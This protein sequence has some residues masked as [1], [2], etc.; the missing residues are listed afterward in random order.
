[1]G[2][3]GAGKRRYLAPF[4]AVLAILLLAL[5]SSLLPHLAAPKEAR[6]ASL[7]RT[8]SPPP[9]WRNFTSV[10]AATRPFEDGVFPIKLTHLNELRL[11]APWSDVWI[12]S[13]FVDSR[14]VLV[15][16]APEI[17]ILG[18]GHGALADQMA[19]DKSPLVCY[20]LVKQR[21][22]RKE[23]AVTLILPAYITALPDSHVDEKWYSGLMI[24]CPLVGTDGQTV[25]WEDADI[26][27][28]V[29]TATHPPP[30][31][32]FKRVKPLP[33][34]DAAQHRL[35]TGPGA[36]C[37]QPLVGDTYA[38]SMRDFMVYYRALG[39]TDFYAYLLDPG[40]ET[41]AI[42]RELVHEEGFHAVRW[43]LPLE[44]LASHKDYR[45]DPHEWEISG[46]PTLSRED[47]Y[48]YSYSGSNP[49]KA[50]VGVWAFA[51]NLAHHDCKF[52]AQEAGNRWTAM[53]DWDEYLLLR[54]PSGVWPP[55]T[56]GHEGS[57]IGDWAAT[58]DD[59][60]A[61]T[62]L[63]GA[64]LF[65]SAFLCILCQPST[66][67][68]SFSENFPTIDL[69][70]PTPAVPSIFV[71]P[72]RHEIWFNVGYRAK[73]LIDPW[74]WYCST[75]HQP[76]MSYAQY[77]NLRSAAWNTSKTGAETWSTYAAVL[78]PSISLVPP[79]PITNISLVMNET[80]HARGGMYHLRADGRVA[81][82]LA[83]WEST[84]NENNLD[85]FTDPTGADMFAEKRAVKEQWLTQMP[86]ESTVGNIVIVGNMV[87]DWTLFIAMSSALTKAI[88][89]RR[90]K[91]L[92]RW[93]GKEWVGSPS[94]NVEKSD[95][96]RR[97]A[98]VIIVIVVMI[99]LAS[100][101]VVQPRQYRNS[102]QCVKSSQAADLKHSN[103]GW[104]ARYGG[105]TLD[106]ALD[107][108]FAPPRDSFLQRRHHLSLQP[109]KLDDT[110]AHIIMIGSS[111]LPD[112]RHTTN[113]RVSCHGQLPG[114]TTSVHL[115]GVSSSTPASSSST[116]P[117]NIAA[118]IDEAHEPWYKRLV[119]HKHHGDSEEV[120]NDFEVSGSPHVREGSMK[121]DLAAPVET[122]EVLLNE[123][124]LSD[125]GTLVLD[126]TGEDDKII[127]DIC[128]DEGSITPSFHDQICAQHDPHPQITDERFHS[129]FPSIPAEDE[130]VEGWETSI[131]VPWTEITAVQ[132]HTTALVVNAIEIT[133]IDSTH[134]FTSFVHFNA[135]YELFVSLWEHANPEASQQHA[136]IISCPADGESKSELSFIGDDGEKKRHRLKLP[137]FPHGLRSF[138]GRSTT[139]AGLTPAE[140][141][142]AAATA[143]HAPTSYDGME[144]E[145]VAMD[146]SFPT[147]PELAYGLIFLDREFLT[148]F[149]VANDLKD[150]K[151]ADWID[152]KRELSYVKPLSA[153]V[154][155][156]EALV[157]LEDVNEKSDPESYYANLTESC[158]PHVP[159]GQNFK[160]LTRT[161]ITWSS[162]GGAHVRV[163]TEVK[164]INSVNRF[165][166]N[167]I[168]RSCIDGQKTYH[169][170][171]ETSIRSQIAANPSQFAVAGATA[172]D[173]S[174]T[175]VPSTPAS[176]SSSYMSTV[177]SFLPSPTA[178]LFILVIILFLSNLITLVSLRRYARGLKEA[179][180]G[181]PNEVAAAIRRTLGGFSTAYGK[182]NLTTGAS[183]EGLLGIRRMLEVIEQQ[184][185]ALRDRLEGL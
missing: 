66:L 146:L 99:Y 120:Q 19:W 45:V 80:I 144:F 60:A 169:A 96:A 106:D 90:L 177:P 126:V 32:T 182:R 95:L 40:P 175:E 133:T 140:Q 71:S 37:L 86:H 135:T 143:G 63:P 147:S 152:G 160:V 73:A 48:H 138:R 136:V 93:T 3:F 124:T 164:W 44:W 87:E 21:Q 81:E 46:V 12:A 31:H 78:R 119:H 17:V 128:V 58:F 158:T 102:A 30:T 127:K 51:Q 145:N 150:V 141:I 33:I 151:M 22:Q 10:N 173:V 11:K 112:H 100:K 91:P 122:A 179:R 117:K 181:D 180:L 153:P 54:P 129:L 185:G 70:R 27:A 137:S 131:S 4:L 159:S 183:P 149:L 178:T 104:P 84:A 23:E 88:E 43:T 29:S 176:S 130:L 105:A 113:T 69:L 9:Q 35:G 82:A 174:P 161:V 123:D 5:F 79:P 114:S 162:G 171:L 155:P 139:P 107:R 56:R 154:G 24:S 8:G 25:P 38:A 83:E 110:F 59:E 13:A 142:K 42:I 115:Q 168:E 172:E 36:V 166:K 64:F 121:D 57:Q 134:T 62:R 28:S 61:K 65:Q 125:D 16:V 6:H 1:M 132:K 108:L 97:A 148:K 89:D 72:V 47:E 41:I 50:D 76:V 34:F 111:S 156:K 74:A 7:P 163:T 49:P 52:R 77:S 98:F 103:L 20:V 118:G 109:N 53:I 94:L 92:R 85:L 67:P 157:L 116:P 101:R 39:F 14:P 55:S 75:I 165:L 170:N 68:A 26:L 2:L 184:V 15:G 18:V 167:I